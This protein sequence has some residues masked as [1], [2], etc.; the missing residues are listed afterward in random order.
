MP[1]PAGDPILAADYLVIRRAT[2]DGIVCR[3]VAGAVQSIPNAASTPLLFSTEDFDPYNLHNNAANTSRITPT[4]AGYY[5]A[6]GAYYS[7]AHVA[8]MDADIFKSGAI[9]LP[10][11]Q[12]ESTTASQVR[13]VLARAIVFCN[14]TTDY[15]E[16]RGNQASGGALNTSV[17]Q[18]YTSFLEL[19]FLGRVAP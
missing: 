18:R 6:N 11:G 1:P 14:G 12:K 4:Q 15:V 2:I 13:G 7:A 17:A 16:I 8:S 19:K 5:E 9:S 3:A 10:S